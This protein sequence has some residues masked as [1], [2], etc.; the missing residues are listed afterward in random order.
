VPTKRPRHLVTET[1]DLAAALDAAATR[2]PGLTRPQLLVRLALVG[3]HAEQRA[4]EQRRQAR[5]A[6]IRRHSG[7]A[8]GLYGRDYLRDLREDWPA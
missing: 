6:A 4:V 5:L 2:W 1:D 3:S 8:T 7:A